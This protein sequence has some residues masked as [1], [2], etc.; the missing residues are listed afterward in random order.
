[1]I[2]RRP[3]KQH[4]RTDDQKMPP[5]YSPVVDLEKPIAM[6]AAT[7]ISAPVSAASRSRRTK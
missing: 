7:V 2:P 6:K 1:M 3:Q 4:R 5:A